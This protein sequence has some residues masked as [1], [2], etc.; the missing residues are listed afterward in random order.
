MKTLITRDFKIEL[1]KQVY[2]ILDLR[3][4][5]FLP[6]DRQN[7][8]YAVLGR[9]L[10]W[11]N[12]TI[13]QPT[14][15]VNCLN[16]LFRTGLFAKRLSNSQASFVT[17]RIDWKSGTVYDAF[18]DFVCNFSFD[19]DFYVM[20]SK[21][22]V[23][24]C[25][26]NNGSVPSTAEPE[27]TLSTTSLEEPSIRTGDGYKWKYLY[28]LSSIQKQKYLT[29]EWMPVSVNK[30]VSAAAINGSIDLV[31][32]VN[33]GNNYVNGSTQNIITVIGDGTGATLRANV[34]GGKIIDVIIQNRGR[35]YTYAD[36]V[37]RDVE[38]GVGSGAKL[39]ISVSP[40]NGH[41]FDPIYELGASTLMF[42]CD[43]DG[44]DP[45]FLSDN[46]YRQVFI[47][48]NPREQ[49]TNSLATGENYTCYF[50]I[51]TSPGVGNF[52]EDEI[53][54]QGTTLEESNFT[55]DVVYFDQVQNFLYLNNVK[56]NIS[57]NESIKGIQSGSIRIVNA[58]E[59]PSLKLFTG[60]V[61][62]ISN[63]E[64]ISRNTNQTDRV[65]F[66]LNFE[67]NEA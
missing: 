49:S 39:E 6:P 46:D 51:R 31:K 18:S 60:K 52:N 20:N 5:A 38:G 43:F 32:I 15:A 22:Q 67:G 17:R 40:Q 24:K 44:N 37:V 42:D 48:K 3:F 35:D 61:L 12:D 45:D 53:V 27:I 50:R 57:T 41:G 11:P 36:L 8:L 54:F 65:R 25:L 62:Y 28:T 34:S 26:S 66:I 64:S 19:L 29:E 13:P 7:Y 9:Q 14:E 56:G 10:P 4:N 33:S 30:F 23:F 58:V 47:L 55:A 16:Q 2:E 63:A 59:E 1:A 21:F